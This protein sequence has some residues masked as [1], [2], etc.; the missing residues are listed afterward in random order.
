MSKTNISIPAENGGAFSAHI[1]M[2]DKSP[3]PVVI[4]IQEIFGVNAEMRA[5]CNWLADLGYIAICPDLFW[6]IEPGIDLVDSDPKQ[7]KRAFELFGLFDVKQGVEDLKATLN[8]AR[9]LPQGNGQ[10]ACIGYCLGGKLAY[11][12]RAH[13][14]IDAAVS[15]YGVGIGAML[16]DAANIK[17]PLLL[18]IAGHDQFVPPEEQ[19]AIKAAMENVAAADV[20]TYPGLDHAFAR[21]HGMH[22]NEQGAELANGRTEAFLKQH[23]KLAKA[24]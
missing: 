22:Y 10:A 9:T 13:T 20:Y 7:L 15:Y 4:L 17:Q 5:K 8:T 3:A 6:R 16:K 11:M 23:L 19:A 24:A 12:M 2:P 14:D 1:V 18:H 21:G